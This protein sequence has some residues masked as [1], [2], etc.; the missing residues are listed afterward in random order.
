MRTDLFD[1]DLPP[2]RI[3]LRP[4]VAARRGA[5]AGGA[6][7]RR[8]ELEDR[9]VRDLPDLL[10]AGRCAG[11]QR[12]QGDPGAAARA[13]ASGA[14][15]EPTIEATLHRAARRLA[16]A[17][18]RAAGQAA[19]GRRLHALRRRGQGLLPRP[20]RRHG[21]GEGRGRRG[22]ARPSLSRRRCSTRRSPS[23]A[24]CRCRPTSPRKRAPDERDRADYQ[25]MFARD[26]GSVAAPTAGLHFTAELLARLA[27]RG[28]G[29]AHA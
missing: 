29:A 11:G 4:G 18:L 10:R 5:A 7:G 28:V 23:A 9:G 12:H 20:A 21:R 2:E 24:T 26:E 25:T 22:D 16:L 14:A 3:A 27:A 6:A 1:F 19:R 8:A 13:G 17:R 15:T